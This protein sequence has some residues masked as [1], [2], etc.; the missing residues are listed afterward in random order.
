MKMKKRNQQGWRR[1][2]T[3]V[4]PLV[5]LA[6][7]IAI[8]VPQYRNLAYLFWFTIASNSVIPSPYEAVM[9]YLGRNDAPSI[10]A[11]VAALGTLIPCFI[12][13]KAITFA[14]QSK[15]LQKVRESEY[16]KGVVYYFLKAPF[17]CI[18]ATALAPFIPFYPIRVLSPT[19][20]YPLK[21][22]MLAV[23]IG[24][25]PR[26]YMFAYMGSSLIPSSL[27]LVGGAI[28]VACFILYSL[29]KRHVVSRNQTGQTQTIP[30]Q[31][32]FPIAAPLEKSAL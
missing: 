25:L 6:V 29:V 21:R 12:D 9:M 4:G 15:R 3:I 23:F 2:L 24:R 1:F 32:E 8:Y 14:F 19:S 5:L 31:I 16:Y 22:Y 11:L 18:I 10:V 27:A 28:I 13:Y 26:Y 7:P 30:T 17:L 20:G